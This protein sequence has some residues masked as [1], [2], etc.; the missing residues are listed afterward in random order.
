MVSS[1]SK[2]R[3]SEVF[4]IE[5]DGWCNGIENYPGEIFPGLIHAIIRELAESFRLALEHGYIFNII[6]LSQKI[7]KSAKYLVHEKE[8]AFSIIANFP[9]PNSLNEEALF[10]MSQILQQV[11]DA[12]GGALERFQ[13]KWSKVPYE[14]K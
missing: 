2:D 12:Y 11:E 9:H 7:Q 1:T 5:M 6:A 3:F 10:T 4:D 13:H 8:I 14:G